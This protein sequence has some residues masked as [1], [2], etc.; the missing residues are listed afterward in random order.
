MGARAPD[1]HGPRVDEVSEP[2]GGGVASPSVP[3]SPY[4]AVLFD[5]GGVLTTS[6]FHA[7][8]RWAVQ[9]GHNPDVV[10]DLVLGPYDEDGDHPFQRAE[11]G[12]VGF[13]VAF[14]ETAARATALGISLDGMW[15]VNKMTPQPEMIAL[16]E[17]IRRAGLRTAVVSNTLKGLGAR[18]RELV[19]I[20]ELVDVVIES[21]EV[22]M[23]KPGPGIYKLALD[24][25]GGPE[26]PI[27]PERAI[28]LDDHAGNIR[29]AE[30][31][32]IR[33][34]YVD[35]DPT[36][37]IGELRALLGIEGC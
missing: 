23:R 35:D 17:A 24:L 29:G 30:A 15:G 4:R 5:F 28:F 11:R 10:L 31:V 6:P 37:A 2:A 14:S 16:A 8:R 34:I 1:V 25:L 19:P 27:A 18:W 12:E 22:G 9:N 20:D 32:G 36:E 13:G 26:G 3:A 33:S 7:M 21:A